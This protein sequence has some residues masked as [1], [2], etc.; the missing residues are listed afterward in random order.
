MS[1][2]RAYVVV[3][4]E[5]RGI[6]LGPTQMFTCAAMVQ[7]QFVA[8]QLAPRVAGVAILEREVDPETGDETDKLIAEI[9]VV[10]SA[11]P[12]DSNWAVRLN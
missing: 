3:P 11:C 7:A 10:P 1:T 8:Q 5:R 12:H 2:P 4:F 9:G 6:H